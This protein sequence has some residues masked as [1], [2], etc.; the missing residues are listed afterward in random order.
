[1]DR[2]GKLKLKDQM[3]ERIGRASAVILAEYRGLTVEQ[4]TSL[5]CDLREAEA[6]LK[7]TKNR[8]TKLAFKEVEDYAVLAD[9]MTGPVAMIL[10]YGDAAAVAKN[11]MDFDKETEKFK[12]TV[13][14]MEGKALSVADLT[15]LSSLPSKE[16]LLSQICGSIQ[17]PARGLVMTLSG[18]ARNLVQVCAAVRDTKQ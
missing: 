6:E 17:S 3:A 10:G 4:L 2:Q 15:A 5:R 8:V 1:M 7:V 16:V 12:V 9:N 13:G 18:V 14:A 11:V